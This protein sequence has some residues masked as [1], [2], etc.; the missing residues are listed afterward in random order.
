MPGFT[1]GRNLDKVGLKSQD[2]AELFFDQVRVPAAN[3][4]GEVGRG[5]YHP[6]HNLPQSG[7]RSPSAR[8]PARGRSSP[9][10]SST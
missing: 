4:L 7:C 5:F 9:A 10:R 2:T 6:M 1:R 3:V 8:S